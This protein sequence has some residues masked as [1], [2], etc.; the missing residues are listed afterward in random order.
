MADLAHLLSRSWRRCGKAVGLLPNPI[1]RQGLRKGVAAAIEH[2]A[3]I[4]ALDVAML[5]DVGANVGQFSLLVRAT[6]PRAR[7]YAFEPLPVAVEKFREVLPPSAQVTLFASAIG[8]HAG[9]SEMHVARKHDS[10][11]L[12]PMTAQLVRIF[13]GTKRIGSVTVPVNP[14][15]A[16]ITAAELVEPALLKID[17]QGGELEVL[18][19]CESLLSRFRYI[20]VELSFVELYAGQPLCHE[21][22]RHLEEKGF[23]LA[24]VNNLTHDRHG[25]PVQ[26]DFLFVRAGAGLSDLL[27][28]LRSGS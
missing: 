17:V 13:P 20:Y 1:F 15:D 19:G 28:S 24:A 2:E 18:R 11:S 5:V 12:L 9:S 7:I 6:H 3:L 16:L 14:L 21:V 4:R 8:A 23:V 10:S 26:A 25:L 27:S 22:L